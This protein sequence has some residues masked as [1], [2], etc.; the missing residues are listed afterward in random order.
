MNC[1]LGTLITFLCLFAAVGCN[2]P[3]A[4]TVMANSSGYELTEE[5][6]AQGLNFAQF[7]AGRD[8]SPSDLAV[9]REQ[10]L[11]AS[12]RSEPGKQQAFYDSIQ[13]IGGL[14]RNRHTLTGA[15]GR[16][17][18]WDWF[19][20]HPAEFQKFLS[21][22]SGKIVVKYNPVVVS[23]RGTMINQLNV[24]SL[25]AANALVAE[26]AGIAPPTQPAGAPGSVPPV[27][28]STPQNTSGDFPCPLFLVL[29]PPC[30]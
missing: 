25:L 23:Y 26:I 19:A 29:L 7:L 4:S 21:Y 2:M 16:E 10:N 18:F 24:E 11:V 6:I 8:F 14:L 28:P 3:P 22:P 17:A 1:A 5:M 9:V 20:N 13:S 27:D 15:I 12:F 30:L